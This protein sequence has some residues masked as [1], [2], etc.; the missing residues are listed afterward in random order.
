MMS[1]YLWNCKAF[2]TGKHLGDHLVQTQTESQ[3]GDITELIRGRDGL[4]FK[5]LDL[6]TTNI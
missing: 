1:F 2:R 5:S 6:K 4:E 3:R